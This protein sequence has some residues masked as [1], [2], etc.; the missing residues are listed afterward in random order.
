MH[1][2]D[3]AVM[4]GKPVKIEDLDGVARELLKMTPVKVWLIDG[5][6]GAG[7]TT[8]IKRLCDQLG[9]TTV[10]TSPTFSIVNEYATGNGEKVYHFDFYRLKSVNEALDLGI[11]E[12]LDSGHYCFMEWSEKIAPLVPIPNVQVSISTVSSDKRL[13]EY[14][15]NE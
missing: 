14:K 2:N 7:K 1:E 5:E 3:G 6:M 11:E 4:Q 9:V 15:L 10:T 12:Y 8:L 13:I